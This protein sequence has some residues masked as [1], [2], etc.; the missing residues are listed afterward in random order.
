MWPFSNR[1]TLETRAEASYT[2]ALIAAIV[3]RQQGDS[4]AIPH[5]TAALEAAAGVVG[6][7]FAAADVT[8]RPIV[9]DALDAG[10]LQMVGRSLMRRGELVLLIDTQAGVLRLLPAETWDVH[11]EPLPETWEY[12]LTLAGPSRTMT[13]AGVPASSVL[14]FRYATDPE[15]PWRGNGPIDVARLAGRL[16][17]ETVNALANE[18]SG[19]IGRL[20]GIPKDGEDVTVAELKR[21]IANAKGRIAMMETG[22]WDSAGSGSAMLDTKRFG[23]EPPD[24][25]VEQSAHASRE[26]WAA[27]GFSPSLFSIGP[28]AALREAWRIA[29]FGVIGP[30]GRMV[31]AEL[32]G[33]LDETLGLGWEELRASDLSGRARAFQSMVGGGMSIDRAAAISGLMAP[34]ETD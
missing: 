2:D 11:G 18:A 1:Q 17:A 8:G 23:A 13:Y 22:D 33:K 7:A 21:D 32:R 29:L 12:R 20:L 3:S 25:L 34:E 10:C 16:S 26:I 6:R 31:Q 15:R 14:H 9:T 19:P 5:A 28:A 24:A 27:C 4:L 30:L